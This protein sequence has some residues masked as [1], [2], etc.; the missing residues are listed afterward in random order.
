MGV[1]PQTKRLADFLMDFK[2][3]FGALSWRNALGQ[4]RG[5]ISG[6][7]SETLFYTTAS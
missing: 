6:V 7:G 4:R 3:D 5:V 2:T 1:N